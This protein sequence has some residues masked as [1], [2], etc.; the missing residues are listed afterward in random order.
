MHACALGLL[1]LASQ[2]QSGTVFVGSERMRMRLPCLQCMPLSFARAVCQ[3][4]CLYI[5][6]YSRMVQDV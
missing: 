2:T 6:Y 3:R 5:L 1:S 4:C